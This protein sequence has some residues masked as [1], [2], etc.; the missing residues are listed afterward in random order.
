[1]HGE[2]SDP[3]FFAA[4]TDLLQGL[5]DTPEAEDA[6]EC[7]AALRILQ[8]L[9]LDSGALPDIPA[10]GTLPGERR[11]DVITRINRGIAASG[12]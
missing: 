5:R 4:Y 2:T 7:V 11:R 3:A 10:D 1:V 9:G 8:A 6:L 12:L